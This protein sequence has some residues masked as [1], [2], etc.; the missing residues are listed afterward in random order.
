MPLRP[1]WPGY[2]PATIYRQRIRHRRGSILCHLYVPVIWR[3]SYQAFSLASISARPLDALFLVPDLQACQRF[4]GMVGQLKW[5]P[6]SIVLAV[7]LALSFLASLSLP[8]IPFMDTVRVFS[9]EGIS[10]PDADNATDIRYSIW[11]ACSWNIDG[12]KECH[13]QVADLPFLMVVAGPLATVSI[14]G[15]L[16]ASLSNRPALNQRTV[17]MCGIST[18]LVLFAFFSV[19]IFLYSRIRDLF[20]RGF[21]GFPKDPSLVSAGPGAL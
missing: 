7:A 12:A 16:A 4:I 5:A 10:V 15:A 2:S 9:K 20:S 3:G 21:H 19:H 1:S 17:L 8:T 18:F 6:S 11:T 14:L 13:S